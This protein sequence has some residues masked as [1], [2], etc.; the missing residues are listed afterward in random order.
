MRMT[1]YVKLCV[2]ILLG[3]SATTQVL[4]VETWWFIQNV[5]L[6][7]HEAGHVIFSLLGSFMGLIGGCLL[8]A[9]V[10]LIATIHFLQ[11]RQ[12]FSA[13][14]GSWWLCTALLSISIYAADAQA[15]ALPL[16]TGDVDT[17]DWYNILGQ[18]GLLRYDYLFGF[19]FWALSALSL[20]MLFYFLIKDASI[21]NILKK[22]L[23]QNEKEQTS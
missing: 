19:F 22:Q 13:A 5:N 18:L 15:R 1:A 10:P 14:F 11:Q 9:L 12:F 8:E 2:G 4:H 21:K 20:C 6:I 16:I 17:H 23:H 3:I 7:F